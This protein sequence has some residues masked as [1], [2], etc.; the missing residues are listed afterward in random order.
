MGLFDYCM[1]PLLYSQVNIS[2]HISCLLQ[3]KKINISCRSLRDTR[4]RFLTMNM[5][6]RKQSLADSLPVYG[7]AYS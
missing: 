1:R 6:D 4:S 5:V 2:H 7:F 3:M